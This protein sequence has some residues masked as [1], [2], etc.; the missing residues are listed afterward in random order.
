MAE[1]GE[2]CRSVSPK[3]QDVIL[4]CL[5]LFTTGRYSV[6]CHGGR[7]ETR[8]FSH[9]RSWNQRIAC[10]KKSTKTINIDCD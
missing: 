10:K 1:N 4:K 5:V 8:T 9:L 7:K 6:Y 2:K 3:A